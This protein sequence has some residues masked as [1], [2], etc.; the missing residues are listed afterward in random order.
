M[1]PQVVF[2]AMPYSGAT[3]EEVHQNVCRAMLIGDALV[4][5]GHIPFVPHL[6]HFMHLYYLGLRGESYDYE[7]WMRITLT[8]VSRCDSLYHVTSPGADRERA[9]AEDLG[10]PIYTDL[11]EVPF[12]E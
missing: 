11:S 10:L 1:R 7:T 4:Q 5:K 12:A 9:L 8:M 3:P 2:V 6:T